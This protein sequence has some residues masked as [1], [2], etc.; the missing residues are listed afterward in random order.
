[1]TN[2]FIGGSRAVSKLNHIVRQ[3]LDDLIRRNCT[4]YIGDANGVDKAVQKHLAQRDYK[5][6]TVYCMCRNRKKGR[7]KPGTASTYELAADKNKDPCRNNIGGWQTRIITSGSNKKDF[8]FYATKDAAMAREAKYGV[9][10]WDGKSKGTLINMLNLM[11][12]TKEVH[13][14]YAPDKKFY[15]FANE[16]KFR[17]FLERPDIDIRTEYLSRY[18]AS[19]YTLPWNSEHKPSPDAGLLNSQKVVSKRG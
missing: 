4:I 5:N 10:L 14:Y 8:A 12:Q 18:S 17:E 2:V 16:K 6:V 9:M 3:R 13:V 1:M 7:Q 11:N 15:E 19:Q